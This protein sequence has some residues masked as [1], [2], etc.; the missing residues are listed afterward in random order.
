MPNPPDGTHYVYLKLDKEKAST[1]SIST[2]TIALKATSVSISTTKT[3]PSFE[4]PVAG[5]FTGESKTLALNLGMASKSISISGTITD[6]SITRR[7]S[8]SAL[9][10]TGLTNPI[11]RNFS[12]FEIAQLLHSMTDSSTLQNMQNVS[13]LVILMDSK[14]G[15]DYNYRNGDESADL[16]PFTFAA[17]G[18]INRLDNDGVSIKPSTFPDSINGGIDGFIRSFSTTHAGETFDI[19]FQ[20]EFEVASVG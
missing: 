10:G 12:K 18:D 11:T 17:R 9:E 5:L 7:F 1:D 14:V 8:D 3:I 13:T 4:V 19:D 15:N 6:Q 20:L 16:V 2:N